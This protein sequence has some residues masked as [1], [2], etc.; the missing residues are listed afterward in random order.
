MKRKLLTVIIM[1][2]CLS[3]LGLYMRQVT[4]PMGFGD[5][6]TYLKMAETPG[7]FA[8]SPWG[9]RIALPYGAALLSRLFSI[10]LKTAFE[11]LQISMF[12]V[13]VSLIIVWISDGLGRGTF[14]AGI[15]AILFVFS[16][17][18]VYNLHNIVHVGFGEHLF[19][20][21]GCIA[22]YNKRFVLLCLIMCASCFVKE[23][24]G[25]LLLPTYF[26]YAVLFYK[27]RTALLRTVILIT[28][29]LVPFL[30]LHSGVLFHNHNNIT[31]YTSFYTWKYIQYCYNYWGGVKAAAGLIVAYYGPLCMIS[32]VGFFYAPSKLKALAVLP[33]LASLQ[34]ALATDVMR[35]FGTGIPILIAL[36]AFTL[37]KI[38]RGHATL[39]SSLAAF[40]FL[41]KNHGIGQIASLK[42]SAVLILVI[43]WMNRSALS[44]MY[45]SR[46]SSMR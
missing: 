4:Q 24:I 19:I 42:V 30:L 6:D 26:V 22:M 12:A 18:G 41:C 34:I 15:S 37:S 13:F 45:D 25:F 17:P 1:L 21:L 40:H 35:M 39:L 44:G 28:A 33:L 3:I 7:E 20:L 31:T 10:P 23:S 38:D 29:F 32:A 36:S 14:V 46:I 8:G 5:S 2:G 9:Y 43:L 16:Y 27:W 11:I